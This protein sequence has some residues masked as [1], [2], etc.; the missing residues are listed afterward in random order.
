MLPKYT[1]LLVKMNA[2]IIEYTNGMQVIKAFGLTAS[3]YKKLSE[4]CLD[5]GQFE[6]DWGRVTYKYILMWF[7]CL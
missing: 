3:S 4:A 5:Y 1:A 7:R 2:A 6:A